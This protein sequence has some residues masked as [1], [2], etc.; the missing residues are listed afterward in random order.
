[1][2][3][4]HAWGFP[5]AAT[6][7]GVKQVYPGRYHPE[8]LVRLITTERVT[9]TH[10][11]PTLLE[12]LLKAADAAKAQ[13]GG[14]KMI[15][16]GSELHRAL[17][18][19]ALAAGIDVFGGFGM[20]ETGP[21]VA[22]AQVMTKDPGD[23]DRELDVRVRAGITAPL[24]E[25][26]IVGQD[27]SDLPHDGAT[28][29]ELVLRSPWLTQGYVNNP[30]ASE[31]LWAGGYLHTGDIAVITPDGYIKITDRMKDVIKS[32]GEWVSSEQIEDLIEQYPGVKEAAVIGIPDKKW[33]ER[34]LALVVEDTGHASRL[35]ETDIKAHLEAFATR[36]LIS[37]YGIPE[38]IQFV[39]HL[40]KTSVGKIDKKVLRETYA[41]LALQR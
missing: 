11:V 18:K 1:M 25:A 4:V 14:L 8:L 2:F 6:L 7:A 20:S 12:M 39:D 28:T 26:R 24:V 41:Q 37:K 13:L 3:H 5:W 29:G 40:A 36:G 35:R 30:E 16:G 22:A 27:M 21:I 31:A 9:F 10:G 23:P 33:G 19:Q 17:A 15:I 32:G 34:P 38:T